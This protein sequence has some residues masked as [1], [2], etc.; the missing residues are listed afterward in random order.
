M[1]VRESLCS[2]FT[3]SRPRGGHVAIKFFQNS[4]PHDFLKPPR[5]LSYPCQHK[6][7]YSFI[8]SSLP[9]SSMHISPNSTVKS[10][11]IWKSLAPPSRPS[12]STLT[13]LE[14]HSSYISRLSLESGAHTGVTS[15]ISYKC[16][17]LFW[18][19]QCCDTRLC[20]ITHVS[21]QFQIR[22]IP[23]LSLLNGENGI[24]ER[25]C[26]RA[27]PHNSSFMAGASKDRWRLMFTEISCQVSTWRS[28]ASRKM[29]IFR[30]L[31]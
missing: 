10:P 6:G 4:V 27:G 15:M 22:H 23:G 21:G 30:Q 17:Q 7:P 9:F 24:R 18:N 25:V 1:P 13:T 19:Q 31:Q 2:P 16:A 14:M 20:T 3:S 12:Q 28:G 29:R 5:S 26:E 8:S 11:V